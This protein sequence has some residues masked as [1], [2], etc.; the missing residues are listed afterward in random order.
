VAE[1]ADNAAEAVGHVVGGRGPPWRTTSSPN[2]PV[3]RRW[4]GTELPRELK[5]RWRKMV[6]GKPWGWGGRDRGVVVG[7]RSRQSCII[8]GS[9]TSDADGGGDHGFER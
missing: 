1:V 9:R 7:E 5:G 2:R 4:R 8:I 3:A 6:S